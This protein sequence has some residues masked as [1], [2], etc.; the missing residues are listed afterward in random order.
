MNNYNFGYAER[1]PRRAFDLND[2]LFVDIRKNECKTNITLE[3]K[4]ISLTGLQVLILD[5]QRTPRYFLGD[6]VEVDFSRLLNFPQKLNAE[7][8]RLEVVDNGY[9]LG[10]KFKGLSVK[11]KAGLNQ[12]IFSEGLTQTEF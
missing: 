12:L 6:L 4:D 5:G 7:V 3:L 9:T 8:V 2:S 1:S 10:L 11:E